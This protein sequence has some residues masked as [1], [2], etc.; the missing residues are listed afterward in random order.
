V[1]GCWC[2]NLAVLDA[3]NE[4]IVRIVRIVHGRLTVPVPAFSI[5]PY[6]G[7]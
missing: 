1:P 6:V 5:Y 3:Q 4:L 2:C 7:E